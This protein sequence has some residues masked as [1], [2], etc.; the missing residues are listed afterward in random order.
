TNLT[1][2]DSGDS[3]ART[4]T[5]TSS[6]VTGLAPAAI[7]YSGAV[8]LTVH[9]GTPAHTFQVHST[10][11]GRT[12]SVQ[13]GDGADIVNGRGTVGTLD[14]ANHASTSNDAVNIGSVSGTLPGIPGPFTAPHASGLTALVVNDAGDTTGRTVTITNSSVTGIAPGAINYTA[15]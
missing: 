11:G 1:I 13:T 4:A 7:N 2:D 8:N 6:A 3:T 12:T 15:G 10:L 14:V 5:I 9:G